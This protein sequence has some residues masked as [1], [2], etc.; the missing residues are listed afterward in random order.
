MTLSCTVVDIFDFAKYCNVEIWI[1]D[2]SKSSKLVPLDSLP[3]VPII[4]Q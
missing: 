4:I 1:R 2:H 3:M